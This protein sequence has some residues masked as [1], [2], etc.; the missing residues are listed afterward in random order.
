MDAPVCS[1]MQV[2]QRA[3]TIK[4]IEEDGVV[5]NA[6]HAILSSVFEEK[7]RILLPSTDT[8]AGAAGAAGALFKMHHDS[9]NQA[10][11]RFDPFEAVRRDSPGAPVDVWVKKKS[12]VMG[13]IEEIT[14]L[15]V[16]WSDLTQLFVLTTPPGT[17]RGAESSAPPQVAPRVLRVADGRAARQNNVEISSKIDFVVEGGPADRQPSDESMQGGPATKNNF[18]PTN[19]KDGPSVLADA[20]LQGGCE[21]DGHVELHASK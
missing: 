1:L 21:Q 20:R 2:L 4:Q 6:I 16:R 18:S 11:Y 17:V 15:D 3:S 7:S 8:P 5:A 19:A 13:R 14:G 10:F 9:D 12:L